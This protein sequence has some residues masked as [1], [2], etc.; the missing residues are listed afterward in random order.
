[1][2]NTFLSQIKTSKPEKEEAGSAKKIRIYPTRKQKETLARWFGT[3]RWTYNKCLNSIENEGVSRSKKDLRTRWIT[4]TALESEFTWALETPSGIRDEAMNDILKA[5]KTCFSQKHKFKMKFRSKKAPTQV[6]TIQG[7]D[8]GR[9]R[10]VYADLFGHGKMK[11]GEPLPLKVEYA[12]KLLKTFPLNEYYLIIPRPIAI[13][14][15]SDNQGSV[16]SLDPGVRT[17]FTCY[18][19][20]GSVVEWGK[21][22]IQRVYRLCSHLDKLC[23]QAYSKTIR[24]RKRYKLKKA[25]AR[26]RKKIRCLVDEMHH[27]LAR[28]LCQTHSIILIPKFNTSQ[29]VT[30]TKRNIGSKTTRAMCTWA[31]YRFRMFLLDKSRSFSDCKVIECDEHY[32]SKTCGV[33]GE[34]N[35]ALGGCKTFSCKTC[36]YQTD[37][38]FNGARNVLLRYLSINKFS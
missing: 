8:Y 20:D 19:P 36:G 28:W 24:H 31:H 29:M 13:E 18:N 30:K 23:S 15:V 6:I 32:T 37:R 3:A 35:N 1:M 38:D 27:K 9:S 17:F 14:H 11:S 25:M 7:R 12:C 22:D 34:L 16:V 10:G 4:K 33:C 21:N 26:S 5:Y 2:I